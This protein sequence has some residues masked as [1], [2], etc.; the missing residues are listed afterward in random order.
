MD[1]E[2]SR[3][4]TIAGGFNN[5]A[6]GEQCFIGGGVDNTADSTS[7]VAGG[8]GNAATAFVSAV[9]GGIDNIASGGE[10]F[11]AGGRSNTASG[12]RS[13]IIGGRDN[14]ASGDYAVVGGGLHDSAMGAYSCI[15]GG[16]YNKASGYYSFAVGYKANATHN[17]AIVLSANN[18][19]DNNYTSSGCDNQ[20]L[21]KAHGGVY[22][23]DESGPAD[24]QQYHLLHT[25]VGAYLSNAGDWTNASDRNVKESFVPVDGADILD[26]IDQLPVNEWNYK[27][28]GADVRH[29]GPVAQD[30][31][32]LFG[33]G[34]DDK[35]ISTI[36]P[37]G[38]ALAAI[39]EL[40]RK[41]Q[42]IDEQ[43]RE[44]DELRSQLA[45]M[46]SA[47]AELTER[48]GQLS[49]LDPR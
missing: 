2:A 19:G 23:T 34:A 27:R 5:D 29:I 7:A 6:S 10:S 14:Y 18:G 3:F 4:S 31:Y 26:K 25:V 45:E 49:H 12:F 36:D 46:N 9:V 8:S 43:Q 28:E 33:V 42:R 47:I 35:S 20:I 41:T 17:G 40:H 11:I 38:I 32:A 22:I 24:C 37:A 21:L 1:N 13:S 39:K 44:I 30:F 16:G 48:W 15:P